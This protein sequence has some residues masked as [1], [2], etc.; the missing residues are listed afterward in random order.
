[1]ETLRGKPLHCSHLLP[2]GNIGLND[3]CSGVKLSM[4]LQHT[5]SGNCKTFDEKV[6][7]KNTPPTYETMNSGV[8]MF[9]Q[10]VSSKGRYYFH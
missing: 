2:F 1:M 9:I 6:I 7:M 8:C 10:I 5:K 4:P 3:T